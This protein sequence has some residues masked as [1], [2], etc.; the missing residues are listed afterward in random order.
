MADAASRGG[1]TAATVLSVLL[2]LLFLFTGAMKLMGSEQVA[3]EFGRFGFPVF[4]SY[5]IG[6]VE[7]SC[8]FLLFAPAVAAYA[9]GMLILVMLGASG[10]HLMA[11][12]GLGKAAVPLVIGVLL[13]LVAYWRR[14]SAT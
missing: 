2:A 12:D 6:L 7:I 1:G 3:E 11:G 13:A 14:P 4:F 9:A 10:S 8:G 5:V